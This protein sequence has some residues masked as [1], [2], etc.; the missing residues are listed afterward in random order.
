M[1]CICISHVS[2]L[3]SKL[4][5]STVRQAKKNIP[6]FTGL[7]YCT[8]YFKKIQRRIAPSTITSWYNLSHEYPVGLREERCYLPQYTGHRY[9]L[10]LMHE[11]I[12]TPTSV[13]L[14]GPMF[15]S[16]GSKDSSD[17]LLVKNSAFL[18]LS[19]HIVFNL[20]MCEGSVDV[21]AQIL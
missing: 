18:L 11:R 17:L 20:H 15:T 2:T 21:E 1:Y 14:S 7:Q 16:D 5:E 6:Q 3:C 4:Y 19:T 13:L 12:H 9:I 8:K 10:K